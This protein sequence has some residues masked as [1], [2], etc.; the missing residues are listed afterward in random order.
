[1]ARDALDE[2]AV[3]WGQRYGAIIRLWE[4]AWEEFIPFPG[5]GA[6]RRRLAGPR[7]NT[8]WLARRH[9]DE[10]R[11]YSWPRCR[12]CRSVQYYNPYTASDR[13]LPPLRCRESTMTRP[14]RPERDRR[15]YGNPLLVSRQLRVRPTCQ[16]GTAESDFAARAPEIHLPPW[17][18]IP[19][20][21][22]PRPDR[23]P[24]AKPTHARRGRK[25]IASPHRSFRGAC[26]QADQ[27]ARWPDASGH[28]ARR[29]NGA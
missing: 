4:N 22:C 12:R 2:L 9:D 21:C 11:A 6:C 26:W 25:E 27:V 1:M 19:G 3:N 24:N 29:P 16:A 18:H 28:S 23:R 17:R 5:Y 7:L 13:V 10:V 20:N 8:E 15:R 14:I